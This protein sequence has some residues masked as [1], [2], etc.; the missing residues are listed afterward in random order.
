MYFCIQPIFASV[1]WAVLQVVPSLT[2]DMLWSTTVSYSQVYTF[3]CRFLNPG[4]IMSPLRASTRASVLTQI[5]FFRLPF[6]FQSSCPMMRLLWSHG[7]FKTNHR[8]CRMIYKVK[9]PLVGGLLFVCVRSCHEWHW[10]T[11]FDYALSPA[12]NETATSYWEIQI[13]INRC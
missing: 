8:V 1:C 13:V 10:N 12:K 6:C 9:H 2:I 7:S 5:Y 3:I 4:F 11:L